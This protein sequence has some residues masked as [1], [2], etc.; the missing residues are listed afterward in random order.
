MRKR[1]SQHIDAKVKI[2][3]REIVI[4]KMMEQTFFLMLMKMRLGPA[5]SL[6]A[7]MVCKMARI[8][9]ISRLPSTSMVYTDIQI[10]ISSE[11]QQ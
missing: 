2:L 3:I 11:I 9:E 8:T 10:R 1:V 7:K 5:W 6:T 4:T